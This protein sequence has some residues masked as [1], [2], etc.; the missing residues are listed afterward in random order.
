MTATAKKPA[1]LAKKPAK[2]AE[3]GVQPVVGFPIL[4]RAKVLFET[5]RDAGVDKS[6]NREFRYSHFTSLI[7]LG[8]FN[9]ILQSLRGMQQA[10]HLEAVQKKLGVEG[11]SL[12]S[13]SESSGVFDPD[14]LWPLVEKLL[15]ELGPHHHGPGPK[16]NGSEAIPETL[17]RRLVAVDGSAL[18]ALPRMVRGGSNWKLHLQFRTLTGQ[19]VCATVA[20]GEDERDV[21]AQNLEAGCI[22]IADRGYERYSLYNKIVSSKSDYVVRGKDRP[23]TVVES[24]PIT[25]EGRA[26]RVISDDIATLSPTTNATRAAKITHSV[27]RIVIAIRDRGRRRAD[28]SAPEEIIILTSLLNV[29]AEVIAA[30]YELRWTIELFFRFLK[31]VLGCHKLF[32]TKPNAIAIQMYCAM[33]ACLLLARVTGGRVRR[34][35]F[36]MLCLYMQGLA[37]LAEL[38]AYLENARLKEARQ[39]EAKLEET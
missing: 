30:I 31:Q 9:P 18:K 13:L 17:A 28:R 4:A 34:D 33:I 22:Y 25:D 38:E 23:H 20:D 6:Q 16:R 10:S 14:L 11:V 1:K 37:T 32:S 27:R 7:L 8:F 2:R 35:V 39:E 26:A 15:A 21:F 24:R 19:P 12:G 5:I 3:A 36:R 29:P